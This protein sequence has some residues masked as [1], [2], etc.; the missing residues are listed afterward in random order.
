MEDYTFTTNVKRVLTSMGDNQI[1]E[2]TIVREPLSKAL[3]S[4]LNRV[5]LIEY[6]KKIQDIPYDTYLMKLPTEN[7]FFIFMEITTSEG[8]YMLEKNEI[9]SMDKFMVLPQHCD[10]MDVEMHAGEITMNKMLE[11]TKESMGDENFFAYDSASNNSQDFMSCVLKSNLMSTSA[12]DAF[13]IQSRERL[14][15]NIPLFRFLANSILHI[16][17]ITRVISDRKFQ[18]LLEEKAE[19]T[20][21]VEKIKLQQKK[22]NYKFV[23]A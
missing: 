17:A 9:I 2:V 4:L 10:R 13:I 8:R 20:V 18:L 16:S 15:N 5:S 7:L 22:F 11:V 14:F 19:A 1:T 3:T 12:N 23:I 6:E 21:L